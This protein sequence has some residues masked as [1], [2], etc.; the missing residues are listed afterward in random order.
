[1]SAIATS[2]LNSPATALPL[3][4]LAPQ[5]VPPTLGADVELWQ[6]PDGKKGDKANLLKAVDQS[7]RYIQTG[8]AQAAYR[9]YPVSGITRER[10]QRSLVRFREL[11]QAAQ[12]PEALS[13]G[14]RREF[15]V[16][17]SVGK[18]NQGTVDFTGYFEATYRASRTPTAEYRYP[19]Y[20]MPV[21]FASWPQ[22]H[23]TRLQLEG[24]DG[25]QASRGLLRGQELVWL[26]DRLEA[27]L[28]QVQ[29]SARLTLTDGKVMTIGVA[30][31]TNYPYASLGKELVKAGKVRLEDLSLPFLL[32]YFQAHPAE[33]DLYIPR[34]NRF[35]FFSETYGAPATG[36]LGF[37]VTAE[38]S[39]ATDKSIMPP[40]ALALIQ[41]QLPF[42]G[43][44]QA[45]TLKPVSH[46]AL[47]QDTGG[48]IK[49]PGRVD[50]FMGTGSSAKDRAG[51]I[52]TPGQLYY[53]LL[54]R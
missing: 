27:Y 6:R 3:R 35:I 45:I 42:Y 28:V 33:L 2:P 48:A 17:Q 43:T 25:L 34:N 23:P 12:T 37:P 26:R 30:G 8:A 44:N 52:N 32:Q 11:L 22:P 41:T 29:G 14:V 24:K 16:Y 7:L 39:I 1:M 46:F 40:G 4:R 13:A 31:K 10:V 50:V 36:S 15:D 53:L 21:S 19:I 20:R 51:L 18:D 9:N 38:R 5:Q 54:K 49:S 47:D